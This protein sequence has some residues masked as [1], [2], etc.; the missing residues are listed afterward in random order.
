MTEGFVNTPPLAYPP[1]MVFGLG[2]CGLV[3]LAICTGST[4]AEVTEWYRRTYRP[5]G[6][7]KGSTRTAQ[8]IAWFAIRG[9]WVRHTSYAKDR[10]RTVGDF[11]EWHCVHD[12]TFYMIRT[13][14]HI[15]TARNGWLIDQNGCAPA[16]SHVNRNKRVLDS[17]EVLR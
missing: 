6:N 17:W 12:G 9:I 10:V 13:R 5:R 3:G 2:N 7:W 8:S 1:D 11:A 15:M 14:G 4:L 16:S